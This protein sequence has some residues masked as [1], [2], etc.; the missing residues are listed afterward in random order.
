MR[1]VVRELRVTI[2]HLAKSPGFVL[3]A[4][5]MLA[6]GIGATTAIFS[7][8][9]GVL[10]RPLPFPHANRLM[11][12]TDVLEGEN[13]GGN[14]EAGVTAL[15][16]TNYVRDAH[17]FSNL[18]GYQPMTFELSGS[19]EPAILN[20]T[21]MT[22]G[23]FPALGVQPLLGRIF[24]RQEDTGHVPVVVLSYA[25][26][27]QRFQRSASVLGRKILLDRSPY[28][29]IG[30]MP[31]SFE[32][33]LNPGSLNNSQL[34][35]PMS[36]TADELATISDA[37]WQYLMVG[38]LRAGVTPQQAQED[39]ASVARATVRSYPGFM[40]GLNMHPVV[41]SLHADTIQEARPL[42]RT[43]F[44]AVLVVLLIACANLAGLLLV[45]ALRRRREVAVRLALGAPARVLLRQAVLES[46]VL[47]VTGGLVGLALAAVLLRVG[48]HLLP[49]T[50]PLMSAIGL[51]WM[52]AAFAMGLAVLT[53]LVCGL[54]PA[55]ASLRTNMN[56]TLK[57]GGRTGTKGGSHARVRS[58]LVV[59]EIAVALVL[60]TASGLLLRSFEKMREIDLG[61]QPDHT[62]VASYSLPQKQYATQPA[63]N[64]FNQQLLQ[65]LQRLPGVRSVGLTSFLPAS[66][67]NANSAFVPEGYAAAQGHSMDLGTRV[68]VQGNYFRA[69]GIPLVRGRLFTPDDI[70]G[71]QTVVIVNRKLAEQSWPGQDPVGKR[72]RLGTPAMQTPWAVVVG[73]V[74]DVTENSPALPAKQ[75]YYFPVEQMAQMYGSLAPASDL[76]GNGGSIVMRTS[77]APGLLEN[78]LRAT[79]RSIDP[80]LPLTQMQTMQEAVSTIEAPRVF[81]TSL[82][83]A[84]AGVALLLAVLG[85]YSVV[86]F[87]V[88]LRAQRQPDRHL[89]RPQRHR[90]C[91]HAV[92]A[93]NS[94]QQR[95]ACKR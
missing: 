39:A 46:L 22:A 15:D 23:V 59:S 33:P 80:K 47:S 54:A 2:R 56:D 88:A 34:W 38:R 20:A 58:A 52:V 41:R 78:A 3:T 24:T 37:N 89:L 73:E 86:A 92:N 43:L 16:I 4:V 71:R 91:D 94:Q 40:A 7:I 85:I 65:R 79:V 72:L 29:V 55:F 27:Q 18:G 26:W 75:Q 6:L 12:L 5:L 83:S 50:L 63:V 19:G 49:E 66:G 68:E 35:V 87:S 51:S 1:G 67:N 32:F 74:Q 93:Q 31:R 13:I 60:L 69:M 11:V 45:R 30:V 36:F 84:F 42:V 61:Y 76:E 82:I 81:Y 62:V 57:E 95:H 44:L 21:R 25:L 70:A 48:L 17:S 28:I 77:M 90:E 9:D 14:G 8:V 53:G 10:L 64:A